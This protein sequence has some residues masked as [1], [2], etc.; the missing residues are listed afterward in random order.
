[1]RVAIISGLVFWGL[2]M[3]AIAAAHG[4][5]ELAKETAK[6]VDQELGTKHCSCSCWDE[7]EPVLLLKP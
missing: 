5:P 4:M 7:N 2:V 6:K 3:T 1:M